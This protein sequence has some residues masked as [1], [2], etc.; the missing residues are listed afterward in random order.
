LKEAVVLNLKMSTNLDKLYNKFYVI[1]PTSAMFLSDK[2]KEAV[3]VSDKLC[4]VILV[5]ER[6]LPNVT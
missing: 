2:S 3:S 1:K 6:G 5:A 4:Q